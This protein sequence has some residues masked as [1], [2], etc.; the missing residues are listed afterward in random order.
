MKVI[1]E[2]NY[3][4]WDFAERDILMYEPMTK[5][6]YYNFVPRVSRIQTQPCLTK[7]YSYIQVTFEPSSI[8]I[9][10]VNLGSSKNGLSLKSNHQIKTNQSSDCLNC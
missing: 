8:S 3:E 1:D 6:Y 5:V 9:S 7:S 2:I 4:S 10:F